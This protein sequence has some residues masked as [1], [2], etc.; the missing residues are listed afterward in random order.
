M[1]QQALS[2][3]ANK[4]N[5]QLKYLWQLP[6]DLV[7]L[8][9]V[10]TNDGSKPSKNLDK[11]L[12]SVVNIAQEAVISTYTAKPAP[13]AT[14]TTI[15]PPIY[16]DLYVLFSANFSDYQEGLKAI[17]ETISFFQENF[18]FTHTNLPGLDPKIDKLT[19]ELQNLNITELSQLWAIHGGHYLPSVVYKVRMFPFASSNMRAEI[20]PAPNN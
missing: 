6:D 2:L 7:I 3:I 18:W 8:A 1:I 14:Y 16:I 9:P 20:S 10:I 12:F 11:L 5:D 19:F 17:T 13:A 4:L 15:A